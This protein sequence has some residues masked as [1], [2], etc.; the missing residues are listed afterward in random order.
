MQNRPQMDHLH[1]PAVVV[2]I[3]LLHGTFTYETAGGRGYQVQLHPGDAF[4]FQF[5]RAFAVQFKGLSP[6]TTT[7]PLGDEVTQ[8]TYRVSLTARAGRY[9]YIIAA[10]DETGVCIDDPEVVIVRPRTCAG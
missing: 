5:D 6:F 10:N 2:T 3:S 8:Q 1:D 9:P 4:R 7:V